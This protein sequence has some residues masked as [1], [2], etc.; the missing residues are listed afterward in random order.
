[1][2]TYQNQDGSF[3]QDSGQ[4]FNWTNIAS[5]TTTPILTKP[6]VLHTVTVNTSGSAWV[7]TVYDGPVLAAN[8]IATITPGATE[9]T[10]TYDV[11][12]NNGLTIVTAGTTAGDL[13][14]AYR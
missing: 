13:T 1:M 9:E 8:K 2:T 6:G 14:V 10:F 12:L 5:N 4:R 11:I 7:I 3:T